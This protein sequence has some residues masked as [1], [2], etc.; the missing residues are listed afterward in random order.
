MKNAVFWGVSE[1]R[2]ISIIR[3]KGIN[4]QGTMLEVSSKKY[5]RS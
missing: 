5:R 4:E 1:E 3:V 2:I